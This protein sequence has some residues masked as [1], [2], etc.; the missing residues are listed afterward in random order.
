[1]VIDVSSRTMDNKKLSEDIN[2]RFTLSWRRVI[3]LRASYQFLRGPRSGRVSAQ[4]ADLLR[5]TVVF[6]HALLED[7]L[8]ELQRHRLLIGGS[9]ALDK[10]PIIGFSVGEKFAFK[11]LVG[12]KGQK[13]DDLLL[14]S[15]EG[16]LESATYNNAAQV[17]AALTS[18]G[19]DSSHFS[20]YMSEL[21]AMSKRRHQIV[22]RGD[23]I[24]VSGRGNHRISSLNSATVDQWSLNLHNFIF[25]LLEEVAKIKD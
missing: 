20:S 25:E 21:E 11:N 8:R 24:K 14:Q 18:C 17:S 10:I 4:D 7:T 3:N 1:M 5:A 23:Y 2:D 16:Y 19:L 12:F 13:V 22:H 6:L 15:V 9:S